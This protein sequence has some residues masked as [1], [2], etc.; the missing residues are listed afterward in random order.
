MGAHDAV[1]DG[2]GRTGVGLQ[3][4][5]DVGQAYFDQTEAGVQEPDQVGQRQVRMCQIGWDRGADLGRWWVYWIPQ[6]NGR[7]AVSR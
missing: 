6:I 4:L 7:H 3:E 5:D 1:Q 2:T